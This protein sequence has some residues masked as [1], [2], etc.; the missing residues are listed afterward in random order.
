MNT[1]WTRY[2]PPL[3]RHKLE[4]RHS[5]RQAIGNAGWLY[6]Y[7]SLPMDVGQLP[8]VNHSFYP[9]FRSWRSKFTKIRLAFDVIARLW[10]LI[11]AWLYVVDN[12]YLLLLLTTSLCGLIISLKTRILERI[13]SQSRGKRANKI[14][15]I[16]IS[17]FSV[18][19]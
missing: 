5:L 7:I 12:V 19:T 3:I 2:L 4:G 11:D 6:A 16:T 9:G 15:S 13:I 14:S 10:Y 1:S 18:Q 8:A 17:F